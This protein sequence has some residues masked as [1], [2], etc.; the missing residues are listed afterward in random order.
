MLKQ[1]S[2]ESPILTMY[3]PILLDSGTEGLLKPNSKSSNVSE[4]E[5]FL[6][7]TLTKI[8][9]ELFAGL[10]DIGICPILQA[11]DVALGQDF[12][13]GL[14]T[15]G[16][17]PALLDFHALLLHEVALDFIPNFA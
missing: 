6:T 17:D 4:L 2:L 7:P 10:E 16:I 5:N 8:S 15:Q 3:S 11:P 14:L 9:D 1:K 13:V 12:N